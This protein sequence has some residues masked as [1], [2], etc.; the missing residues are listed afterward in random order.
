M[1]D[2]KKLVRPRSF[3]GLGANGKIYAVKGLQLLPMLQKQMRDIAL[4]KKRAKDDLADACVYALQFGFERWIRSG[5]TPGDVRWQRESNGAPGIT[6]CSW[7]YGRPVPRVG[8]DGVE[9][10]SLPGVS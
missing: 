7:G 3:L 10:F 2:P 1:A 8:I 6:E 5:F 9:R 4:D